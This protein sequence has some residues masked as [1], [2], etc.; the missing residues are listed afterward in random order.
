MAWHHQRRRGR[1]PAQYQFTWPFPAHCVNVVSARQ[2]IVSGELAGQLGA[3]LPRLSS[4]P[5]IWI[6]GCDRDT[7]RRIDTE[8]AQQSDEPLSEHEQRLPTIE[9]RALFLYT[10]GTTGLPKAANI[11]HARVMQWGHWFAGMMG[12]QSTERM[13]N[14]LPMYHS[15]GGV[16]VPGAILVAGGTIVIRE[17]FSTSQFWNDVVRWDCTIFQCP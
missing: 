15:V 13:Y 16:Q 17:K 6:H 9:D 12:A 1:L 8:I 4:V 11:S 5:T 7:Y 10:S 14:C 3:L 2:L